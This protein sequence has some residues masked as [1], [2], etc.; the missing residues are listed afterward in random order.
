ML[1][2]PEHHTPTTSYCAHAVVSDYT[3]IVAEGMNVFC[4]VCTCKRTSLMT[5]NQPKQNSLLCCNEHFAE[6][7][8]KRATD[9][10]KPHYNYEGKL[11]HMYRSTEGSIM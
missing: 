9:D 5:D 7:L 8:E 3:G 4:H 10:V 11:D 1:M 2:Y 6:Y